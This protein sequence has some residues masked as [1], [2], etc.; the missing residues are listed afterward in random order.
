MSH[1]HGLPSDSTSLRSSATLRADSSAALHLPFTCEGFIA[2]GRE[3]RALSSFRMF[4]NIPARNAT[5]PPE[6]YQDGP[7]ANDAVVWFAVV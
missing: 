5:L 3:L 2:A 4:L 6:D 1:T 7:D